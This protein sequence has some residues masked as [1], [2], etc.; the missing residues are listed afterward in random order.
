MGEGSE[1]NGTSRK[2]KDREGEGRGILVV[3]EVR[4]CGLI[5]YELAEQPASKIYRASR[6]VKDR[7]GGGHGILVVGE[8]K[9]L[10]NFF[11]CNLIKKCND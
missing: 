4:K 11:S 6:K 2:V 7:E 1:K 8:T 9:N 10:P 3:G 5:R